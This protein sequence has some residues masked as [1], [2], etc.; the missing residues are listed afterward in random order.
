[1]AIELKLKGAFE[2]I[3]FQELELPQQITFGGEQLISVHQLIGGTRILDAL[4]PSD[5][6]MSWAGVF[7]TSSAVDR[8]RFCD[9]LRRTG[10]ECTL[11]WGEFSYTGVISSFSADYTRGGLYVPYRITLSVAEDKTSFIYSAPL[12]SAQAQI[13]ADMYRSSKLSGCI[14]DSTLAGFTTAVNSAVASV[15]AAIQPIAKGLTDA[16]S[17]VSQSAS[18]VVSVVNNAVATV[19]AA[20]T[21]I[22][23]A[24]A[25][26][27]VLITSA[28]QTITGISTAGGLL[29]G[30]P[31]AKMTGNFITQVNAAIQLPPLY[32]YHAIMGRMSA[33]MM[34][35]GANGPTAKT[36]TIGG[37]SLQQVA[38]QQYGDATLWPIIAQANNISD[39]KLN[40]INTLII[41]PRP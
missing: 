13:T 39:P 31:V 2:S 41:P 40:G 16:V 21:P 29:P 27:Q 7:T 35:L 20:L 4:G 6:P 17:A 1:M 36:I 9:T 11:T 25:Q 32:E 8:A 37:G 34:V 18:C 5:A 38:A 15:V 30:N 24:Q 19:Q 3:T 33:N 26:A 28:E 22:A 12:P 10:E 23:Q 14:G